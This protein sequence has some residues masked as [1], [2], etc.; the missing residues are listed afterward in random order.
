MPP[1]CR[2]LGSLDRWLDRMASLVLDRAD[3]VR[4][5][6]ALA[7]IDATR[8]R[9]APPNRRVLRRTLAAFK[10]LY[11]YYF[12]VESHGIE[13]VPEKGSVLLAANHGG[14]LP[15]DAS[16]LIVDLIER[17]EPPRLARA[18]VDRWAATVPFVS[19]F[20][21]RT[22]QVFASRASLRALLRTEQVV[23]LFPEGI[24]AI[25]KR[26][27]ERYVLREFRPAF[28]EES[29]R[30]RT[31]IVPV[32]IL[33]PDDQSPILFDV[34]PLAR[35]L[36]LPVCPITPTFP[37]LGPAGLLPYPV[38]YEIHYGEPIHLHEEFPADIADD[39]HA[40]TY[41]AARVRSRIQRTIDERL[42]RRRG[43]A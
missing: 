35:L 15:F 11:R 40:M 21:E 17:G 8:C 13:H 4:L 14:L 3:E 39:P 12:R 41:L 6:T 34:K 20:Y 42:A 38:K 22:G 9:I 18:I 31:P 30:H 33:G 25:R 19:E 36:G 37:W 10:L 1:V 5:R 27:A 28:V 26:A 24:D 2:R 7:A 23:L 32:A 29:L 43:A 16:M